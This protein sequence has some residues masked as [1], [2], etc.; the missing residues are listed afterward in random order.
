[1]GF[2]DALLFHAQLFCL[3]GAQPASMETMVVYRTTRL[4][5][6]CLKRGRQPISS[7][8][9]PLVEW[10][11]RERRRHGLATYLHRDLSVRLRVGG[12]DVAHP[13]GDSHR[14]QHRA[15][16]QRADALARAQ[17]W[18]ALAWHTTIQELYADEFAG[19][20][21]RL[22]RQQRLAPDEV[23]ALVQLDRPAQPCFER[24]DLVG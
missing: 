12:S 9:A 24:R 23:H 13:G 8:V 22:L 3:I 19:H 6:P 10:Q 17:E 11:G 4:F 18:I 1:M 16:G 14:W 5:P 21:V 2:A 7:L 20:A 15:A